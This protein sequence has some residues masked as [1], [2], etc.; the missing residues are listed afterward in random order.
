M[1]GKLKFEKRVINPILNTIKKNQ[2]YLTQPENLPQLAKLGYIYNTL[3]YA[4]RHASYE[5][6]IEKNQNNDNPKYK[7]EMCNPINDKIENYIYDAWGM[8]VSNG[9]GPSWVTFKT[10]VLDGKVL[11]GVEVKLLKPNKTFDE[12]V[13]IFTDENYNYN[14]MFPDRRRVLDYLLCTIGTGYGYKDGFIFYESSGADQD[15]T[16]YGDWQNA[17]FRTDIQLVVDKIMS[18]SDVKLVMEHITKAKEKYES[19]EL[20]KEIESFGMPYKTWLKTREAAKLMGHLEVKS[21]T[22]YSDYY[23]IS[24]YSLITNFD[25]NTHESY[26]KA[27][28]EVCEDIVNFPP[29]IKKDFNQYQIDGRNEVIKFANE[30]LKKFKK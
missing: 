10:T 11:D 22:R 27:G 16:D 21:E 28:I 25:E 29:K 15:S 12:W 13:D 26:I 3:W 18:D 24:N 2:E 20:A 6:V 4:G 19:D 7:I 8:H 9:F 23:P 14:S 17:K 1:K 30:Y 5:K